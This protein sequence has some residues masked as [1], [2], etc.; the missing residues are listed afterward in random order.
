V[1]A[2]RRPERDWEGATLPVQESKV[3]AVKGRENALRD[4]GIFVDTDGWRYLLYSVAR[5]SGLAIAELK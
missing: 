1:G 5:E 4:P 3:G 2:R